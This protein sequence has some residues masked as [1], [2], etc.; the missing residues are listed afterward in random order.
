MKILLA[1]PEAY[2]NEA[3]KV[4]KQLGEVI[5][6]KRD[7]LSEYLSDIDILMVGVRVRVNR[8]IIDRA[9]RLRLIGSSTTA[10]DHMDVDYIKKKGIPLITL[11]GSSIQGSSIRGSSIV[12][13]ITATVE[14]TIGLILALMRSLPFYFDLVR[15]YEWYRYKYEA[16]DLK[17]KTLGII[18]F[19]RIGKKVARI[20]DS[21]E[22]KVL[23][24]DP[25]S[26]R[27][28]FEK[29]IPSS[30]EDVLSHSDI[31]TIHAVLNEETI[32]LMNR[33]RL[34]MMK[35]GAILINTARGKMLESKA[36]LEALKTGHLGGAALDVLPDEAG[37]NP[38]LNNPLVEYARKNSNLIITPHIGGATVESMGKTSLDTAKMVVDFVK[39]ELVF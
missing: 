24:Y 38:T 19:G 34:F 2:S 1:E 35:K 32:N 4:L 30:L 18:G 7:D 20:A 37:R 29:A 11:R 25:D 22:M 27:K 13:D 9:K 33:E 16:H 39:R 3:I 6:G 8:E 10:T 28:D 17:G 12:K 21:F 36:L 26:L 31:I 14:H 23:A 5:I 15:S